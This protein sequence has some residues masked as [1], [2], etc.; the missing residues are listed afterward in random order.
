MSFR[1][2]IEEIF[3]GKAFARPLFYSYPAGLRFELSESGTAIE[4][5]L[6]ALQKARL[7]CDDLFPEEGSLVVCLRGYSDALP[8][9]YRPL[10]SEL[11]AAGIKIPKDRCYWVEP[12][13]R[14]EWFD[15]NVP[16]CW[17]SVAFHAPLSQLQNLLWCAMAHDFGYIQPHLS[18]AIYLF[19]LEQQV[20]ALPYD[21][22]GMD[23]V[24]PNREVLLGLYQKYPQ[25]LL[26]HD[27]P[28]MDETFGT[29][30]DDPS[31]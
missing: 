1:N 6:L 23:V 16:Q 4:M 22:R 9:A 25:Y 21:D 17:S 2:Q 26:D 24:G 27:R 10:Y 14:E 20:M 18:C 31:C 19:N 30:A 12:A 28:E 11:K 13:P 8:S 7:I 15:E 3:Q 5:F 29:P